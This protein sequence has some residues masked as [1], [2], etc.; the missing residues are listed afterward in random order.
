MLQSLHP[1]HTNKPLFPSTLHTEYIYVPQYYIA[2]KGSK[3]D[4]L[5]NL[6]F[7]YFSVTQPFPSSLALK[8][9]QGLLSMT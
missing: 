3:A 5:C 4:H 9:N 6:S 1:P 2:E 7:T 8:M